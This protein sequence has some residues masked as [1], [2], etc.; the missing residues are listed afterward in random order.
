M[1]G[2][3]LDIS[4]DGQMQDISISNYQVGSLNVNVD[5][6]IDFSIIT[7][8]RSTWY[9]W[10]RGFMFIFLIIYHINQIVK[11]LRGYNVAD[12]SGGGNIYFVST[13]NNSLNS[14]NNKMLGGGKK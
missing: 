10:V 8:Y 3:I 11:F 6:F 4:T 5:K 1:F 7:N 13:N 12:G 9:V 2:T 14:G